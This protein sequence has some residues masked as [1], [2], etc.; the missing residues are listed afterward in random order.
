MDGSNHDPAIH[1]RAVRAAAASFAAFEDY[2][3]S[4]RSI[5]RRAQRRFEAREWQLGQ[6]DAVERIEQAIDIVRAL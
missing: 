4:F 3:E 2:N 1:A 5:T 6:R